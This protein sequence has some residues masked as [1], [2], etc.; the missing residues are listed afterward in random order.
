MCIV[1]RCTK[2]SVEAE[3]ILK[4]L[5]GGFRTKLCYF[6][7]LLWPELIAYPCL[8]LVF[9][10]YSF[11]FKLSFFCTFTKLKLIS[12]RDQKSL[13]RKISFK[14]PSSIYNPI[15][16][17]H[18]LKATSPFLILPFS[19]RNSDLNHQGRLQFLFH[20]FSIFRR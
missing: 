10:S 13:N 5:H 1:Q 3:I 17:N 2:S 8:F 7:P 9:L 11:I 15:L 4:P 18:L 6:Q 20:L 14:F 12:R 16:S 19:E